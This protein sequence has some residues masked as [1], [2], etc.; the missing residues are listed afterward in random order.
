MPQVSRELRAS[1]HRSGVHFPAAQWRQL[2]LFPEAK[3][4]PSP[5]ERPLPAPTPLAPS[6]PAERE[7]EGQE[8]SGAAEQLRET[9][10]FAEWEGGGGQS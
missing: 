10:G 5:T 2:L 3:Q 9:I 6:V 4:L 1:I 7:E 8:E